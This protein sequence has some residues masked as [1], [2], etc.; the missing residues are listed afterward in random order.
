MEILCKDAVLEVGELPAGKHAA[1]VHCKTL[2]RLSGIP[3]RRDCGY[4]YFISDL[5]V[6]DKGTNFHDLPNR[7]MAEDHI[8]S[9][10]NRACPDRMD[11]RG[12]GCQR[13]WL[14][15]R[16]HRTAFGN[17]LLDPAGRSNFQHCE[18]LH[19]LFPPNIMIL[20]RVYSSNSQCD[21]QR[22]IFA[23]SKTFFRRNTDVFQGKMAQRSVKRP[24]VRVR[25]AFSDTP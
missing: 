2:L 23:L 15:N 19:G 9:L 8:G 10:T 1:G 3:V 7:L 22:G 6:P 24:A 5:E 14:T 4:Q 25:R 18:T 13:Q 21:R 16:I 17:L 20:S 11:V 12:A